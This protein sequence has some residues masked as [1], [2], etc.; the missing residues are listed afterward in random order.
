MAAKLMWSPENHT[1]K[2][3]RR[4]RIYMESPELIISARFLELN[5]TWS[6]FIFQKM[7]DDLR[8][9]KAKR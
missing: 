1:G 3:N 5:A 8:K 7:V 9:K 4:R 6:Q 2:S